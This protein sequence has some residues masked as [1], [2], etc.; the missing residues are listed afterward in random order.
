MKKS[1]E[2]EKPAKHGGFSQQ[3]PVAVKPGIQKPTYLRPMRG[4]HWDTEVLVSGE[5][6][7]GFF[8]RPVTCAMEWT[9]DPKT[10]FD[11]SM[12]QAG[13]FRDPNIFL[14]FGVHLSTFG[15]DPSDL[16]QLLF[17][18]KLTFYFS[19]R[20]VYFE[21]ML[22]NLVVAQKSPEEW[23]MGVLK[24]TKQNNILVGSDGKIIERC[25]SNLTHSV[26][27]KS[28]FIHGCDAVSKSKEKEKIAIGRYT[29]QI[30]PC[31]LFSWEIVW[32]K[33]QVL[34]KPVTFRVAMFG[35]RFEP[36]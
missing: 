27:P 24:F 17:N 30:G 1:S 33:P 26:S 36:I 3:Y 13:Q 11:T 7:L 20:R 14:L 18:G 5:Q 22:S 10:E 21:S 12:T 31:E 6:R 32:P 16:K 9:R 8:E 2:K 15:A 29:Y 28:D 23:K 19:N 4:Y 25:E 35:L 34:K